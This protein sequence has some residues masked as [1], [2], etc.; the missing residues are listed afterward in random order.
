MGL[1]IPEQAEVADPS[2]RNKGENGL[3]HDEPSPEYA[4]YG[5]GGTGQHRRLG[6]RYG[7]FHRDR[8]DWQ[9]VKRLVGDQQRDF[10]AQRPEGARVGVHIAQ[11]RDL[12]SNQWV[13]DDYEPA[14]HGR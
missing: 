3:D 5:R 2:V 11:H 9:Q 4:D 8:L 7:R 6:R 14:A 10:L 12:V 1:G 13:V